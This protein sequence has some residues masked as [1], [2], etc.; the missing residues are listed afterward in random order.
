[1]NF[2]LPA[3]I[4]LFLLGLG[5][6]VA[7]LLADSRADALGTARTVLTTLTTFGG[8]LLIL[9]AEPP[10]AF[11]TTAS[12]DHTG[13][14]RPALIAFVLGV[15]YIIIML[16]PGL[17]DFFELSPLRLTD[18]GIIA[19]G[20]FIWVFIPRYLWRAHIFERFLRLKMA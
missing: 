20:L 12:D 8:L 4:T 9:F 14:W 13:D 5:M 10:T 17:R 7:Y 19:V 2:V 18:Y 15:V 11:W 3:G 1:M 16:I 6:F